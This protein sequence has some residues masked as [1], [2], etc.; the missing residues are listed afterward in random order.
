M[1][2]LIIGLGLLY[3]AMSW[4]LRALGHQATLPFFFLP[5]LVVGCVPLAIALVCG[6]DIVP[7]RRQWPAPTWAARVL[8][9]VGGFALTYWL[10]HP[11]IW[12]LVAIGLFTFTVPAWTATA[13]R[14]I[15]FALIALMVGYS[16]VWTGNYLAA[17]VVGYRRIDAALFAFDA[18][19]LRAIFPVATDSV[20][21]LTTQP[22][23]FRLLENAYEMLFPQVVVGLLLVCLHGSTRTIVRWLITLFAAY[24]IGLLTFVLVPSVGPPIHAPETF[25]AAL[26]GT[27]TA[28]MMRWMAEEFHHF[29]SG[30]P[31]IGFGYFVA[32]PSLHV[33]VSSLMQMTLRPFP[34]LF[35]TW[36]PITILLMLS[37]V[38]LGYH[39][40][41]DLPAG[42]AVGFGLARLVLPRDVRVSD[43]TVPASMGP[44]LTSAVTS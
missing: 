5:Y 35:W 22:V 8:C 23:A 10:H 27:R 14:R 24:G 42:L 29:M 30:G 17:A 38:V 7:R 36:L 2:A 18:A 33:A 44:R 31:L 11:L 43:S 19:I 6:L 16:C 26:A 39:Y 37:T 28:T 12:I 40:V 34:L 41:I 9:V 1:T 15:A 32:L 25:Q 4:A 3:L 20:Y 13:V 21:P